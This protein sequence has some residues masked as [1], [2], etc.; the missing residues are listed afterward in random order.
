[1]DA[2]RATYNLT[3][4][5]FSCDDGIRYDRHGRGAGAPHS[6]AAAKAGQSVS[7]YLAEAGR[8]KM[9]A[10]EPRPR[11]VERN[12]E[13]KAL[14]RVLSGPM[15]DVTENGRMPTAEERNARQ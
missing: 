9:E 13:M 4:F 14:E 10:D 3:K 11:V 2:R 6:C 7:R 15:W 1:V 8:E 5:V 12:R